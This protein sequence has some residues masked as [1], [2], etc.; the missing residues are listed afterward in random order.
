ME[1][2]LLT[3]IHLYL[4][5]RGRWPRCWYESF[6]CPCS[7]KIDA[8]IDLGTSRWNFKL[9]TGRCP[10]TRPDDGRGSLASDWSIHRIKPSDWLSS[11]SNVSGRIRPAAGPSLLVFPASL[12]PPLCCFRGLEIIG[13]VRLEN[14]RFDQ[15]TSM[16]DINNKCLFLDRVDFSLKDL[17]PS[18]QA[19]LKQLKLSEA[20]REDN[21]MQF[22]RL[23]CCNAEEVVA[24]P[25]STVSVCPQ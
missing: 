22:S 23:R 14:R 15:R 8:E 6:P 3:T 2:L 12:S 1:L 16:T 11:V 4:S 7:D 18:F 25:T 5:Q 13:N 21:A 24:L 19:G 20:I 17:S 9:E 10:P